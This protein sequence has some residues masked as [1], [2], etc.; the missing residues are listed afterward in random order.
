[1]SMSYPN[2]CLQFGDNQKRVPGYEVD[3]ILANMPIAP[4]RLNLVDPATKTIWD[5]VFSYEAGS[6]Y[7]ADAIVPGQNG[8]VINSWYSPE[9]KGGGPNSLTI[10]PF[11]DG[12]FAQA[13]NFVDF[14]EPSPSDNSINTDTIAQP[15]VTATVHL[16]LPEYA[17]VQISTQSTSHSIIITTMTTHMVFD[18]IFVIY[19]GSTPVGNLIT[20]PKEQGCLALAVYKSETSKGSVEISTD[21]WPKIPWYEWPQVVTE[22][23]KGI[24][25]RGT[26][27]IFEYHSPR[28]NAELES[29]VLYRAVDDI[30]KR[31]EQLDTIRSMIAGLAER[32]RG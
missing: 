10:I 21:R 29:E 32:K 25:V 22:A 16:E 27:E 2:P 14:S 31:I 1:M 9:G 3:T 4:V 30:G 5:L 18:K 6:F 19:G 23:V 11:A 15:S 26:G 8:V 12:Q 28:L 7:K 20:V 13:S 17:K 24:A